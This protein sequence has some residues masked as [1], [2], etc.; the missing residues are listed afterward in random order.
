MLR[1]DRSIGISRMILIPCMHTGSS[2]TGAHIDDNISTTKPSR[3]QGP[4]ITLDGPGKLSCRSDTSDNEDEERP[5]SG[6]T[7]NYGVHLS[8]YQHLVAEVLKSGGSSSGS[9]VK[10]PIGNC[11]PG[12]GD[13][14]DG[15]GADG[16]DAGGTGR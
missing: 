11:M 14:A 15:G 7:G 2:G 3:G 1:E 16:D 8:H 12:S 13:Y 4:A 6:A 5:R 10:G 9:G